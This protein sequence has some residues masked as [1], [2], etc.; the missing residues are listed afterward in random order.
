MHFFNHFKLECISLHWCQCAFD[1][2]GKWKSWSCI[3]LF[4]FRRYFT[5]TDMTEWEKMHFLE[6]YFL[7]PR[8]PELM[9]SMH[10]FDGSCQFILHHTFSS[11]SEI[12]SQIWMFL[13][14]S[15]LCRTRTVMLKSFY[16]IPEMPH[17]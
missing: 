5:D 16:E 3:I 7:P 14:F 17:L 4:L 9:P 10:H 11:W 1:L 12:F 6:I 15:F 13:S 2:V 8:M